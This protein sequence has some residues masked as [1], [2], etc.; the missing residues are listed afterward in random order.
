MKRIRPLVYLVLALLVTP[1]FAQQFALENGDRVVFFGDSITEQ[2][3]YTSY[4]EQYVL[5]HY[6]AMHVRFINS[7]WGGDTVHDNP[8]V[9]C[10]GV[11]ALARID[12]DV[13]AWKPTVVTLLFGM[14]D[15]HY[16]D[17]DAALFKEY[18]DGMAEI[19]RRI[20][21]GAPRARIYVMTPTVYDGTRHTSWSH[22]DKYNDTLDRYS[23]AAKQIAAKEKLPVIDLHSVTTNA[24]AQAKKLDPQYTFVDDGVH[25]GPEG[26]AVM[27]AEMLRVWGASPEGV[28][29][30]MVYKAGQSFP[31]AT[32]VDEPL[33]WPGVELGKTIR[34]AFP[35]VNDL[36][37]D[38]L[39]Y[40]GLPAGGYALTVDG[41]DAGQFTE[42]ELAAGIA[43]SDLSKAAQE[44]GAKV[45]KEVRQKEDIDFYRW[46]NVTAPYE[47]T[48][49]SAGSTA[50]SMVKLA[51]ELT[52]KTRADAKPHTYKIVIAKAPQAHP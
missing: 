33:P 45:A 5:T 49:T 31:I 10:A 38:E 26:Q 11:G 44:E 4:V 13:I 29:K 39:M 1:T 40:A 8:C 46:R 3:L 16:S 35:L 14:N 37:R 24:L 51:D 41:G 48:L 30:E 7:G 9:P 17:F 32:Q 25:P 28:R 36:G 50:A 27:A 34:Q 22:T 6:P 19:I 20:R 42:K 18:T 23:E 12:R 2:K 47:K 52:S 43:L 21:L 15:G